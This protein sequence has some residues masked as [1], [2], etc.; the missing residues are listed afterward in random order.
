M[1]EMFSIKE[2]LQSEKFQRESPE[3]LKRL[4]PQSSPFLPMSPTDKT[5]RQECRPNRTFT[6]TKKENAA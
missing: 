6:E 2:I 1:Q 5:E 4:I 3:K